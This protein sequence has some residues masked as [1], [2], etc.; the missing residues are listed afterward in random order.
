MA[1]E[2][3][4]IVLATLADEDGL[5]FRARC[6]FVFVYVLC[7]FVCCFGDSSESVPALRPEAAAVLSDAAEC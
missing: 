4:T 2:L 5:E 6:V 7:M 3:P 1:F